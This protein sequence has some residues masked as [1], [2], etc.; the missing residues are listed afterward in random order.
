MITD[1]DTMTHLLL[2]RLEYV[3][4]LLM[5]GPDPVRRAALEREARD[6]TRVL[7]LE[8]IDARDH[9]AAA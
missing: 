5:R 1:R 4:G 9:A 7:E 2:C 8:I 3:E 6:L